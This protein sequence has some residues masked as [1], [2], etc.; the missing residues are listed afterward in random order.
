MH[1]RHHDLDFIDVFDFDVLDLDLHIDF[2]FDLDD[3][4]NAGAIDGAAPRKRP[5][6]TESQRPGHDAR[7][8][9][10]CRAK[11]A[12]AHGTTQRAWVTPAAHPS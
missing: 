10:F 3:L 12:C 6:N 7:A 11:P 1:G 4:I 8:V 9:L 2:D 5:S